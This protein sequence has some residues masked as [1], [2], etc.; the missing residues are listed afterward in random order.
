MIAIAGPR[1]GHAVLEGVLELDQR[2][3]VDQLAQL[4]LAQQLAQQVAIERQGGGAALGVRRIALVHVGGDVVEQQ[5]GGERRGRGG[6]DLDQG[7]P[8]RA[9][10]AEDL[11][12]RRQVEHVAEHLAVGLQGDRE[13]RE[14]PGDLE[15]RLRLQPLLPQRRPLAGIG[16]RQKQRAARRLAEAGAEQRRAAELADDQVLDFVGLEGDQ[17]GRGSLVGVG[18]VD[19]DP[20][21]GPDRVD[22]ELVLLAD[23]GA[24]RHAP[25]RVDAAAERAEDAQSPVADLVA[26][27][28]DHDRL[29]GGNDAGRGLLLAQVGDEVLGGEPVEVVVAGE[30]G[31]VGGDGLARELPDRPA[32]LDRAAD[33]VAAPERHRTRDA[34]RGGDDD[35]VAGDLLDPPGARA[36]QEHLTGAR[37]VDH[38]LVELADPAPVR[39]VHAVEATVGDRA[40]V[41]DGELTSPLA[42]ANRCHRSG[43]RRG[44][45]GAR[46]SARRGS[47]HR[48]CQGRS[49]ADRARAP[50]NGSTALT[51]ALELVDLPLAVGDHRDD[52]LGEHVEWVGA[53]SPSP[54]SS[55][56]ASAW[57]RPRTRAGRSGTSG[58]SVPSRRRRAR[59]LPGRPAGSLGPPTSATRPG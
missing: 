9:D 37:L 57:R 43:P 46:R 2:H 42:A 44:A 49:R 12:E 11:G 35:A 28:L 13:A 45:G 17:L 14:V 19:D 51:I 31:R 41:G 34:R 32:E 18:Q 33:P 58:R 59:A 47:A 53:G 50:Q 30:V 36:E 23:P 10:V 27:A 26:E 6:L 29:I 52:V 56:R 4:L 7:D 54:R 1:I 39:Q 24:Q 21:V 5:R 38:L 20:V 48:A 22:L 25:G 3:R 8:P 16:P 15:Q 55:P 40:G